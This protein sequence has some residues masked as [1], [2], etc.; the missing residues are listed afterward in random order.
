MNGPAGPFILSRGCF[1]SI[2]SIKNLNGNPPMK[3][4]GYGTAKMLTLGEMGIIITEV[5]YQL[6]AWN[7]CVKEDVNDG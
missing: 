1:I 7:A 5:V 6:Y 2:I 3:I 4:H